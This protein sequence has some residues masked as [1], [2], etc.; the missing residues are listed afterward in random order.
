MKKPVFTW[1]SIARTLIL[2]ATL[3]GVANAAP[4]LSIS[5]G[6]VPLGPFTP[7][8]TVVI[9]G[10]ATNTSADQV[11]SICE[12]VCIGNSLTYS[13]GARASIPNGY[14]FRFGGGGNATLGFLDGKL[15]GQLLPGAQKKFI[16]GEFSPIS[17]ALPGAYSFLT[18]VQIFTA[19]SARTMIGSSTFS[20]TWQVVV[21]EPF[22]SFRPKLKITIGTHPDVDR[23]DF[24]SY[25]TLGT[26]GTAFDP[27]TDVVKLQIGTNTTTIPAGDFKSNKFRGFAFEG[28]VGGVKVLADIQPVGS[29]RYLVGIVGT[30][31][32]LVGITN[33]VPVTLTIGSNTGTESV[34]AHIIQ[35]PSPQLG[36]GIFINPFGR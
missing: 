2:C 16:F 19:D 15:A 10:T 14:T 29:R 21:P 4:L 12:G 35:R 23:F 9:T 26:N 13:L 24:G 36:K 1:A 34:T 25:L 7:N 20:G 6:P 28:L 33:P 30:G 31:A 8:E 32:N 3:T 22:A 18:Q 27:A 5:L 17:P 11:I